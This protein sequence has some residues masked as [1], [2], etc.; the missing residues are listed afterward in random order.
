MEKLISAIYEGD[1]VLRLAENVEG[2]Q[3][4]QPVT[5]IIL[6]PAHGQAFEYDET[7]IQAGIEAVQE[8]KGWVKINNPDW[9]RQIAVDESLLE[10]NPA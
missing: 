5:I 10:W 3:T 2:L 4:H 8:T 7:S 9:A 6:W 1:G